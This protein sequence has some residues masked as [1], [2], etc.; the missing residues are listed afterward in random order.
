MGDPFKTTSGQEQSR[1]RL[2][3]IVCT[4]Q[5]GAI[6]DEHGITRECCLW[7]E[8]L[9]HQEFVNEEWRRTRKEI[10]HRRADALPQ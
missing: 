3:L 6:F 1:N 4:Q 2:R 5:T 7:D 8:V 10:L 9:C